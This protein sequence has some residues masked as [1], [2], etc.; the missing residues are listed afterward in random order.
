[1]ISREAAASR[2]RGLAARLLLCGLLLGCFLGLLFCCH[3]FYCAS[4]RWRIREIFGRN[5]VRPHA[6]KKFIKNFFRCARTMFC[7]QYRAQMMKRAR[8]F[9]QKQWITQKTFSK[10][11]FIFEKVF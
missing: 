11:N 1:L 6:W 9:F 10:I 3:I 7:N 8:I 2:L 4:A 5:I